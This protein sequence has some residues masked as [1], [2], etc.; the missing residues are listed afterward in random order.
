MVTFSDLEK[1]EEGIGLSTMGI[2]SSFCGILNLSCLLDIQ[3]DILS[4]QLARIWGK[5]D[6]KC[7]LE[8]IKISVVFKVIEQ[9]KIAREQI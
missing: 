7:N 6:W 4:W 2:K 3:V 1:T 9:N 5:I 8:A